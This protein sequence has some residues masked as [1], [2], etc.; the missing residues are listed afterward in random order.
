MCSLA[1]ALTVIIGLHCQVQQLCWH[2]HE[3]HKWLRQQGALRGQQLSKDGVLSAAVL[4]CGCHLKENPTVDTPQCLQG[5]M[6]HRVGGALNSTWRDVQRPVSL[7]RRW[8]TRWTGNP[9]CHDTAQAHAQL[10]V[11]THLKH[12]GAEP[13]KQAQLS[14]PEML[15]AKGRTGSRPSAFQVPTW[16]CHFCQLLPPARH[17]NSLRC[18]QGQGNHT[19]TP[20]QQTTDAANHSI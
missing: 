1:A 11:A 4:H 15:K 10:V 6:R 16:F 3:G 17:Q 20:R 2:G 12:T 18:M 19:H 5:V 14:R 9:L 8:W 13:H 7:H